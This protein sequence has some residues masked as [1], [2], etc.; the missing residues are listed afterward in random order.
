MIGSPLVWIVGVWACAAILAFGIHIAV[1]L[2]SVK[3]LLLSS[4]RASAPAMWLVPGFLLVSELT[5]AATVL[6]LLLIG[7]TARL[8]VSNLAP[9]NINPGK[10][11]R[12]TRR[13][14]G[15]F[16]QSQLE[17]DMFARQ[18]VPAIFG[19]LALQAG[20]CMTWSGRPLA[21]AALF[22][23]GSAIWTAAWIARDAY[24]P[25]K[26]A[27]P[28][29]SLASI[30]LVVGLTA[31]L[32]VRR[33]PAAPVE[34]PPVARLVAPKKPILLPGKELVPGV[35]LRPETKR[36]QEGTLAQLPTRLG[37][38][39]QRPLTFSF[40]GEYHLFP[41]SSGHVQSDSVVYRGTPLDAA[42]INMG[43]SSMETEAYQPFR[44]P[45]DCSKCGKVQLALRSGERS[46]ASATLRLHFEEGEV[47]LG[48]QVFGF[49]PKPEE[50]LEYEVPIPMRRAGLRGI[51]V[52]FHCD[53]AR[54]SES[55]RVAIDRFTFLPVATT[56]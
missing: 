36:K 16:R 30:I 2:A 33:E 31:S 7:N 10:S 4:L 32:S 39:V 12:M 44:L 38:L 55:T 8:L 6:G 17:R 45:I 27:H 51:R 52:V 13:R 20:I 37:L 41:T 29:L 26:P 19:A 53:P 21:A 18:T 9:Q 28:L 11:P 14:A 25:S 42:Y 49:E 23:I 5:P 54:R 40:T 47:D 56:M 35:I 1:S 22:A 46:P 48:S 15:F 34:K 50:T 43:G 24:R 3:R